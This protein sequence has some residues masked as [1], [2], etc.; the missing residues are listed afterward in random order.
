MWIFPRA[1]SNGA[2]QS[3]KSLGVVQNSINENLTIKEI[4]IKFFSSR[5]SDNLL[6]SKLLNYH[7][8]IGADSDYSELAIFMKKVDSSARK[9]LYFK[10]E[11]DQKLS[12]VLEGLL[13]I[14]FPEFIID[15]KSE[16]SDFYSVISKDQNSSSESSELQFEQELEE[17]AFHSD[18][19]SLTPMENLRF[20]VRQDP[21]ILQYEGDNA[22]DEIVL[23]SSASEPEDGEFVESGEIPNIALNV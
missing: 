14:E 7:N 1:I 3:E 19:E 10:V 6:R 22:D 9:P 5:K 11:L 16:I 13:L 4:L 15:L 17:G 18:D 21:E 2:D 8:V 23:S 20:E 12:D